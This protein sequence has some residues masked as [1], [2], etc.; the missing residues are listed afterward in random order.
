V[1]LVLCGTKVGVTMG[2]QEFQARF[3]FEGLN[4][5]LK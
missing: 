1:N 4:I 3:G 5:R 2:N